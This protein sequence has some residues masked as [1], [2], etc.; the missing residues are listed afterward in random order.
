MNVFDVKYFIKTEFFGYTREVKLHLKSK[1]NSTYEPKNK[2]VIFST[3]RSG[4]TLLVNL[5]NTNHQ[6]QCVGELLRSR[7]LAPHKAINLTEKMC[8]KEVFGFKLLTY[9][10]LELQSTVTDK[11]G[12]LAQLVEDDYQIIYLERTNSLLQALSVLYA[13]QRNVWHSKNDAK[14]KHTKITLDPDKLATMIYECEQFK[15]KERSLLQG[16]PYLYLNYENDLAQPENLPTT[17]KKLEN[18]LKTKLLL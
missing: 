18:Y 8:P 17:I 10:L 14:I 4:S 3:G 5:L 7:N 6:V 12:F 2:F 15:I 1:I 9:Q 11:K 13:M 16:L